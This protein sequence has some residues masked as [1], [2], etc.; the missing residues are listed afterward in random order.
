MGARRIAW[1]KFKPEVSAA[2]I[3]AHMARC[4]A[5]VG[6]VPAVQK[7]ECGASYTDRLADSRTG[8]SCR[9]PAGKPCPI[10]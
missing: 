10:I 7:L 1:L 4:R 8:S 2:Q 9:L 3:E 5:L 6:A